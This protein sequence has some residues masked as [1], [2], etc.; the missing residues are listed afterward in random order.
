M[1]RVLK[2]KNTIISIQYLRALAA[3]LVLVT[4]VITKLNQI[5]FS[6]AENVQFDGA[7]GVDIFFIIS[8]YVMCLT[9]HGRT[10]G[11]NASTAF[12][13][14][15][16]KRILPLYWFLTAAA[17]ALFLI[18]P[19][20]VNMS[21]GET[22]ILDSFLLLPSDGK[23]LVKNGWTLVYEMY[24]YGIFAL[25]LLLLSHRVGYALV[26]LAIFCPIIFG[27][28]L[29]QGSVY[30]KLISHSLSI[31]FLYG[32]ALF[33]LFG[34][35]KPVIQRIPPLVGVSI[36]LCGVAWLLYS[37]FEYS[38]S[39]RFWQLGLPACAIVIGLLSCEHWLRERPSLTLKAIGDSSY[40]L[41]LVHPFIL[42]FMRA[43]LMRANLPEWSLIPVALFM[44]VSSVACGYM[45]YL[46][47]E[48]TMV[49]WFK[50]RPW[51]EYLLMQHLN[52]LR[53][54][55]MGT[56]RQTSETRVI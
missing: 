27:D 23:F 53:V 29:P 51:S 48:D 26:S 37:G 30:L 22:K 15:R 17:L 47:V 12:V 3:L 24:F 4:H 56:L 31:E 18:V 42:A 40:S 49:K 14:H 33:L 44:I 46:L 34:S 1:Q 35:K 16:L 13:K 2:T 21:G 45:F 54:R 32:I 5:G 7:I 41:Y 20:H 11:W 43:L 50:G 38:Y 6:S 28:L 8:G 25:S 55:A 9:T 36:S 39:G 19:A 10:R 52:W